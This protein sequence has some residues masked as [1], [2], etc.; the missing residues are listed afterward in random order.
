MPLSCV[1]NKLADVKY[2]TKQNYLFLMVLIR[3]QCIFHNE[4]NEERRA[5]KLV[6]QPLVASN[7]S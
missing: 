4:V 3:K 5:L 6:K 2:L 7:L 1:L